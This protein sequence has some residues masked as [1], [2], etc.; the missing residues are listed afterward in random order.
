[1]TTDTKGAIVAGLIV[2]VLWV[3]AF[4]AAQTELDIDE[5]P[6]HPTSSIYPQEEEQD[7]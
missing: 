5:N 3:G 6:S 4:V 7:G 1:M 2:L